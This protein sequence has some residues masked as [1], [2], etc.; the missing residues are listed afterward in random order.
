MLVAGLKAL[1]ERASESG[2]ERVELGMAH[3]GRLNVLHSLLGKPMAS[4]LHAFLPPKTRGL[5]KYAYDI[6]GDVQ[7]HL[8]RLTVA[9]K[10]N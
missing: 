8:V 4:L 7:Y 1:L 9:F 5:E 2:V 6:T 10:D 3:R